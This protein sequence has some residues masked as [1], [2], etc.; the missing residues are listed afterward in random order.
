[1]AHLKGCVEPRG[2]PVDPLLQTAAINYPNISINLV[3]SYSLFSKVHEPRL[4]LSPP[5]Y[6]FI[7]IY[8]SSTKQYYCVWMGILW[9]VLW[10]ANHLTVDLMSAL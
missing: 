3:F 2:P 6:T 10:K 4:V 1:M 7:W 5:V 9:D 8:V